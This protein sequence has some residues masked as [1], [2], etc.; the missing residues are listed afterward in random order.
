MK[1][2]SYPAPPGWEPNAE[3]KP[4]FEHGKRDF[5]SS[6]PVEQNPYWPDKDVQAGTEAEVWEIGWF[7]EKRVDCIKADSGA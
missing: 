5:A 7:E 2:A 1:R 6:I 3:E 4:A